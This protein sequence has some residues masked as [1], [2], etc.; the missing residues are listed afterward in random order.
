MAPNL[1]TREQALAWM[2]TTKQALDIYRTLGD[3]HGEA[4]ALRNLG[5]VR[6]VA[7]DFTEAAELVQ[8]ALDMFRTLGDQLGGACALRNLRARRES[9]CCFL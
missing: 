1:A 3:R 5:R 9:T 6:Q 2:R 7:G 8:Q 4:N